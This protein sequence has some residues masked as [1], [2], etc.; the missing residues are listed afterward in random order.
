MCVCVLIAFEKK[1]WLKFGSIGASLGV[2]MSTAALVYGICKINI[3][4]F[5]CE[6]FS[7]FI[8]VWTEIV[9][10]KRKKSSEIYSEWCKQVLFD[11][12]KQ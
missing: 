11:I 2:C 10:E 8:G 4:P 6:E 7:S 12:L 9:W 5:G 3:D 1:K